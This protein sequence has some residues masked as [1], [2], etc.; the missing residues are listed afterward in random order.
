ML[1]ASLLG[2]AAM[3]LG[4]ATLGVIGTVYGLATLFARIKRGRPD[5]Y[6]QQRLALWLHDKGLRDSGTIRRTGAW[7]IGRTIAP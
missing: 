1:V 4:G 7:S 6:Y 2:G 5:G 3:G